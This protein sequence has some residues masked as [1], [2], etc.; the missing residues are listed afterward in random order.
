MPCL[1]QIVKTASLLSAI[2]DLDLNVMGESCQFMPY[3]YFFEIMFHPA[4]V[5][6][7]IQ[8]KNNLLKILKERIEERINDVERSA[9]IV[10]SNLFDEIDTDGSGEL[11]KREF[12][13]LFQ[14][15]EL[16][17]SD[18]KF[19]RLFKAIDANRDSSIS[20]DEF[21]KMVFPELQM[22]DASKSASALVWLFFNAN[23][24]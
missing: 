19:N 20:K 3:S 16:N 6:E 4:S 24:K 14:L 2:A 12:S 13:I 7:S 10:I 8:D 11:S 21:Y 9:K 1:G 22:E 23:Y 17:Y 15:L 18:E 5:F